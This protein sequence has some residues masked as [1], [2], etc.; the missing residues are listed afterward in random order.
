MGDWSLAELELKRKE[1]AKW[2]GS[3]RNDDVRGKDIVRKK[4]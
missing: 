3:E 1:A 2:E 4:G